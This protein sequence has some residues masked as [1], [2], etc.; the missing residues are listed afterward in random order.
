MRLA[1]FLH[2]NY[3]QALN[4]LATGDATLP[5]LMQDLGIGDDSM[6]ESWLEEEKAYLNGLSREP[7]E[8]TLQMEYWQRLVNL[9]ASRWVFCWAY[10]VSTKLPSHSLALSAAM[11]IFAMDSHQDYETQV[12]TTRKAESARRHAVE[13]YDRNLKLVQALECKLGVST[14]W[15][16]QDTDW[17][18]VGR[19]V[20][21]RK[22]QRAL[23]RLEGLVVARIF[24]LM[25]MN[26]AGTGKFSN[27]TSVIYAYSD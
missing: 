10:P 20:A 21:N 15:V 19:L 1:N 27:A 11:T 12:R 3:K 26:R 18:K 24:E 25:K 13:D 14:R 22:Y 2:S 16:P 17:Q 23:D 5:K 4:I 8:E 7:E 6:F 9:N